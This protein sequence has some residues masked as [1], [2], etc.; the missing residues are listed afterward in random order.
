MDKTNKRYTATHEWISADGE[1]MTVGITEHAQALLGDLVFIELPQIGRDVTQGAELGVVESV[2][3]AADFYAPI[4]GH[5]VAVN[6]LVQNNAALVNQ[7]PEQDGWLV[8][9]K[10]TNAEELNK[11]LNQEQYLQQLS[12][13]H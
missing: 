8:K 10:A 12:E 9:I 2:K 6:P 13:T 3:A 4:S 1:H 7:S 11:L 5:V